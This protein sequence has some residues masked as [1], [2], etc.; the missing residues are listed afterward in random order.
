MNVLI[1]R[2]QYKCHKCFLNLKLAIM[3][4]TKLKCASLN[5]Y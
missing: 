5:Q 3:L 4:N 1:E 2:L